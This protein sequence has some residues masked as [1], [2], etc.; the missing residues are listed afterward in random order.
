MKRYSKHE[1]R[2]QEYKTGLLEI[3]GLDS[4]LLNQNWVTYSLDYLYKKTRTKLIHDLPI[5]VIGKTGQATRLSN[6]IINPTPNHQDIID[7]FDKQ[8]SPKPL[9]K[10][11]IPMLDPSYSGDTSFYVGVID[12]YK[13]IKTVEAHIVLSDYYYGYVEFLYRWKEDL[14][15]LWGGFKYG[16]TFINIFTQLGI[17]LNN[18][19]VKTRMIPKLM[20]WMKKDPKIMEGIKYKEEVD[21]DNLSKGFDQFGYSSYNG[22]PYMMTTE[23]WED[24]KGYKDEFDN[25][26]PNDYFTVYRAVIRESEIVGTSWSQS[27]FQTL[28]WGTRR[29]TD[30]RFILCKTKV[31][32]SDVFLINSW[33]EWNTIN[34]FNEIVLPYDI[35]KRDDIEVSNWNWKNK[36]QTFKMLKHDAGD[37][38]IKDGKRQSIFNQYCWKNKIKARKEDFHK[39]SKQYLDRLPKKF[40]KNI[41]K[42]VV[43]KY[44]TT[45]LSNSIG[46]DTKFEIRTK[47]VMKNLTEDETIIIGKILWG[48]PQPEFKSD[49]GTASP[50]YTYGICHAWD[51]PSMSLK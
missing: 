25:L 12:E 30:G 26:K 20:S 42:Q 7:D 49:V 34:S 36:K 46:L 14:V 10:I 1:R 31:K 19:E 11:L 9:Q 13:D 50:H 21:V 48:I 17:I 38:W 5:F 35:L 27:I 29:S 23:K 47:D 32:K 2:I 45:K 16:M 15:K 18:V 4:Q 40:L 24:L 37:D 3:G 41:W 22:F 33:T 43:K 44:D 39:S 51:L 28:S 6:G 8:L